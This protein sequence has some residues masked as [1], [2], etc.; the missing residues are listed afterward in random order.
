M[1]SES[2]PSDQWV[3]VTL[4]RFLNYLLSGTESVPIFPTHLVK[5]SYLFIKYGPSTEPPKGLAHG[6]FFWTQTW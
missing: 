1:P 2:D 5:I 3:W 4:D 6:R